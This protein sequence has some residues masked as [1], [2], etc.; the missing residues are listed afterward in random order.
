MKSLENIITKQSEII[1]QLSELNSQ[2]IELLSQYMTCEEYENRLKEIMN[3][4]F[5]P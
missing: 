3:Y 1:I 5:E 4:T 2:I